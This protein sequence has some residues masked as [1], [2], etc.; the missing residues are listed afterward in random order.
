MDHK[1]AVLGDLFRLFSKALSGIKLFNF[2]YNIHNIF[3]LLQQL[4]QIHKRIILKLKFNAQLCSNFNPADFVAGH[5]PTGLG[6][7]RLIKEKSFFLKERIFST[8]RHLLNALVS[9]YL[10]LHCLKD[11]RFL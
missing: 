6:V 9:Q 7:E 2:S 4:K 3:A 8:K 1:H 11:K 5:L 10:F